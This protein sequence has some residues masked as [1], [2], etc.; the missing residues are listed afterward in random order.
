MNLQRKCCSFVAKDIIDRSKKIVVVKYDRK[1]INWK[2]NEEDRNWTRKG[3]KNKSRN[4]IIRK[5]KNW[6]QTR[7]NQELKTKK[8]N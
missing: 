1:K 8:K 3:N 7:K 2:K 5:N 4:R 6:K